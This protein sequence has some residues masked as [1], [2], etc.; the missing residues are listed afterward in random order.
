MNVLLIM[1]RPRLLDRLEVSIHKDGT[2]RTR[3]GRVSRSVF[4]VTSMSLSCPPRGDKAE[5]RAVASLDP[6]TSSISVCF[7]GTNVDHCER[8]RYAWR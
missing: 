7:C 4:Q 2:R 5:N 1:K 8:L 6:T 3:L